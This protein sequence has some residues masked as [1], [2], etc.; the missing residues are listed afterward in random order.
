MQMEFHYNNKIKQKILI[1]TV[2]ISL[3]LIFLIC[4]TYN[5]P[6]LIK[7]IFN[8]QCPACGITRAIKE[9]LK[10]NIIKSFSY[11]ILA[12]PIVLLLSYIFIVNIFNTEKALKNI[13]TISKHYYIISF[14]IVLSWI[15]NIYRGI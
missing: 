12:L 5:P 2:Y 6:C 14:M 15:I 9:I 11:N 10:F 8:I 13:Q 7:K 4:L 1:L 3:I